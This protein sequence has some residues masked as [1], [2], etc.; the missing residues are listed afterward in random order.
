L[1]PGEVL[2]RASAKG[3]RAS[4]PKRFV[5]SSR[6]GAPFQVFRLEKGGVIHGRVT[7]GNGSPVVQVPVFL[8]KE[9]KQR[10]GKKPPKN[11]ARKQSRVTRKTDEGGRFIF[12]DLDEG[13]YRL[14]V[15]DDDDPPAKPATIKLGAGRN[16][17]RSFILRDLGA[18]EARVRGEGGV[19]CRATLDLS[20]GPTGVKMRRTTGNLGIASFSN[21]LPGKYRLKIQAGGYMS[22]SE[23]LSIKDG[24]EVKIEIELQKKK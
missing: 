17:S 7:A 19:P 20:G 6:Y 18:A 4:E 9:V 16:I 11:K 8:E 5:V 15:A 23:T 12:S 2:M 1:E 22:R 10:S 21:L 3:Y 14:I 24:K 13:I